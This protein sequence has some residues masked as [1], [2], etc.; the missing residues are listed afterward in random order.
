MFKATHIRC[1]GEDGG[2]EVSGGSGC[3]EGGCGMGGG[4]APPQCGKGG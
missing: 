4:G 3:G 2:G 1:E